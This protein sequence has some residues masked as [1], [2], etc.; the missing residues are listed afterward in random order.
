MHQSFLGVL[1]VC[2]CACAGGVPPYQNVPTRA[3]E[4]SVEASSQLPSDN[5]TTWED[6]DFNGA[7]WACAN[8][9][10]TERTR[11]KNANGTAIA[12][13]VLSLA[14][15]LVTGILAAQSESSRRDAADRSVLERPELYAAGFTFFG[16]LTAASSPLLFGTTEAARRHQK[17]YAQWDAAAKAIEIQES[18][19]T[20]SLFSADEKERLSVQMKVYVR[21][22]LSACLGPDG[23]S[24]EPLPKGLELAREKMLAHPGAADPSVPAPQ[25]PR[26][27]PR[28]NEPPATP[29][30]PDSP[31]TP[32]PVDP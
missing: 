18:A 31:A 9:L 4:Q 13:G 14:G 8:E 12:S 15:A 19:Y 21:R 32:P 30:P 27:S 11:M 29:V 6:E 22:C 26:V 23:G 24:P 2:L 17:R 10:N 5:R 3:K 16:G 1:S 25:T 20:S 7:A 28:G